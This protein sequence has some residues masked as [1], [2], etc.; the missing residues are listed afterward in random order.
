M[1]C[2]TLARQTTFPYVRIFPW[3]WCLRFTLHQPTC[4]RKSA[5]II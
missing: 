5:G 4:V 2:I 3:S 1:Y